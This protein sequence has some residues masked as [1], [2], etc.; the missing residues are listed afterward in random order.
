MLPGVVAESLL[1]TCESTI[2]VAQALFRQGASTADG[3]GPELVADGL[4]AVATSPS[5]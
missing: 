2:Q 5:A 1:R 4:A 3:D